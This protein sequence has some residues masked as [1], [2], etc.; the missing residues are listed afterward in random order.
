MRPLASQAEDSHVAW[1]RAR[2]EGVERCYTKSRRAEH[3][4]LHGGVPATRALKDDCR[5]P[6]RLPLLVAWRRARY[7]GVESCHRPPDSVIVIQLH[8]G[9]PAT[10]ALKD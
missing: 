9:V 6:E 7:E 10:R 4:G 8:G 2:Y 3:G 1:R 5:H